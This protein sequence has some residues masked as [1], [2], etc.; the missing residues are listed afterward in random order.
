MPAPN[1]N[2]PMK[3]LY[4]YGTRTLSTVLYSSLLIPPFIHVHTGVMRLKRDDTAEVSV[5]PVGGLRSHFEAVQ[6]VRR[7][8]SDL[9]HRVRPDLN[10]LPVADVRQ[11]RRVVVDAVA[12]NILVQRRVPGHLDGRRRDSSKLN[13][14]RCRQNICTRTR[15]F[16]PDKIIGLLRGK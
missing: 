8:T 13:V 11:R 5:A 6:R 10:A 14:R 15:A 7:Q 2:L 9:G 4:D 16:P 1:E 12:D 3:I